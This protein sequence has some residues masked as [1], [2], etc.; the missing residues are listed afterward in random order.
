MSWTIVVLL[1]AVGVWIGYRLGRWNAE[2]GRATYDMSKTWERR[3]D[4]R[5]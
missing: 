3:S 5:S 4:Y 2:A 1:L